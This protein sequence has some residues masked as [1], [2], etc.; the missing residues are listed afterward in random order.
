MI[1]DYRL[2]ISQQQSLIHS[3]PLT[4]GCKTDIMCCYLSMSSELNDTAA[5][6]LNALIWL[7]GSLYNIV[8]DAEAIFTK[9]VTS[10]ISICIL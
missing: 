6:N 1:S 8:L 2:L 5:K 7:K 10:A 3:L 4:K 9:D